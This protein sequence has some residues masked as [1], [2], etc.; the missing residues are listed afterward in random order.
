MQN[1]DR[2]I[3]YCAEWLTSSSTIVIFQKKSLTPPPTPAKGLSD[4]AQAYCL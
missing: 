2:N 1:T 4:S 3:S